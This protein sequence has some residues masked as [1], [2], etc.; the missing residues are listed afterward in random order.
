[1]QFKHGSFLISMRF[2]F[3]IYWLLNAT[4]SNKK[5]F[6]ARFSFKDFFFDVWS[7]FFPLIQIVITPIAL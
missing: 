7:N 4:L 1:M 2:S 5:T 6:A 3:A